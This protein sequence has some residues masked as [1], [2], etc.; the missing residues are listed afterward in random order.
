MAC[1]LTNIEVH[2]ALFLNFPSVFSMLYLINEKE[3]KDQ[4]MTNLVISTKRVLSNS[5]AASSN[6]TALSLC[7]ICLLTLRENDIQQWDLFLSL[8]TRNTKSQQRNQKRDCGEDRDCLCSAK[9]EQQYY[10]QNHLGDLGL[11]TSVLSTSGE[12]K[13]LHSSP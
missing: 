7:L 8:S 3:T 2:K 10:S 12:N 9:E 5:L 13:S 4:L 6:F 1:Y 11:S